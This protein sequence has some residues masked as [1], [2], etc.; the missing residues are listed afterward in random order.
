MEIDAVLEVEAGDPQIAID[1]LVM[2]IN[3][4]KSRLKD[5]MNKGGVWRVTKAGERDRIRRAMTDIL[6][7][8]QIEIFYDEE[9]LSHKPMK[10]ELVLDMG[11]YS[12]WNKPAGM[13]LEGTDWGDFH[14]FT[15]AVELAFTPTREIYWLSGLDYEASGLLVI[16]HTRKAALAFSQSFES[17]GFTDGSVH[18]R[19]DVVGDIDVDSAIHNTIDGA[20]AKT[21]IEKVKYDARPN[22]SVIDAWPQTGQTNQVRRHLAQIDHPVVGDLEYGQESDEYEGLRMRAVELSFNCPIDGQK[23]QFSLIK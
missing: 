15:R 1:F 14:A 10:P 17:N 12:V 4:S 13:V 22:R 21:F 11:Q 19:A 9:L 7:G 20:H 5:L 16:A 3:L 6:V 8:E 23:Q 2:N 18:Y